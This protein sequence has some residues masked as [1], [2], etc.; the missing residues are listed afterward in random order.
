M[1]VEFLGIAATDDTCE[2]VARSGP[3]SGREPAPCGG[4]PALLPEA[5]D[6]VAGGARRRLDAG[7][8]EPKRIRRH[9]AHRRRAAGPVVAGSER[10]AAAVGCARD[11]TTGH[12]RPAVRARCLPA[13]RTALFD[14]GAD[15]AL[16]GG[17]LPFEER[18]ADAPGAGR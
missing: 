18:L 1:P 12:R 10:A 7:A 13:G 5:G 11:L 15:P 14:A 4:L 3:A 17:R 8:A 6:P 2:T 16:A 9:R